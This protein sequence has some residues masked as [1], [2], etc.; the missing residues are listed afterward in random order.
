M[1]LRE[2]VQYAPIIVKNSQI[3]NVQIFIIINQVF[4]FRTFCKEF[5]FVLSS[6][7]H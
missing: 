2:R 4:F 5:Q 6:I 1:Q 3:A 7:E